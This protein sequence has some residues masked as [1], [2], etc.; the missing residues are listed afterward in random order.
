MY[1]VRLQ[2]DSVFSHITAARLHSFPLPIALERSP[3]LHVAFAAPSRAPHVNGL[4]GHKLRFREG[5]IQDRNGIRLT[6]PART[7][8]DLATMLTLLELVAAGDYLIHWEL[9]MVT[10]AGLARMAEAFI[11]R[12]GVR[13]IR[14]ALAL[15]DDRAESPPESMLRAIIVLGGLPVPT[16]NHSIVDT[17]TG[18]TVRPDFL[19]EEHRT[20]L[21]YQGDYHRSKTQWRKDMTR[22]SRLET[23]GWKVMELNWDDLKDPDE[24]VARIRS[25][26]LR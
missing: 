10:R 24:L 15:L 5:D 20:L 4:Q 14:E 19:F 3:L 7:W 2:P 16:I 23:K 9:P 26:L 13:R 25:L 18:K 6:S 11:G 8:C 22:R 12:R 21:E 1:G 17:T